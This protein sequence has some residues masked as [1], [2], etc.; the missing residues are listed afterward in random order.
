VDVD[1]IVKAV[2][3]RVNLQQANLVVN[4]QEKL[5]VLQTTMQTFNKKTI[6]DSCKELATQATIAPLK[7]SVGEAKEKAEKC[8]SGVQ[9]IENW[10]KVQDSSM[11][12]SEVVFYCVLLTFILLLLFFG[13]CIWAN[14]EVIHSKALSTY[15]WLIGGLI[16]LVNA[17]YIGVYRWWNKKE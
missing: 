1:A 11:K 5:N 2:A 10:C 12:V 14:I 7:K 16:V 4:F 6:D 13:L 17:A 15:L 3:S 8:A 9:R